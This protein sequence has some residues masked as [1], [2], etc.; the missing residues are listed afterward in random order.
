M[1][2]SKKRLIDMTQEELSQL[3]TLTISYLLDD[4]KKNDEKEY[5]KDDLVPRLVVAQEFSVSAVTIDKWVKF[6][7]FPKPIK[8]GRK[9]FFLREDLQ[10]FISKGKKNE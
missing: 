10:N 3:L 7:D 1:D 6:T 2:N 4:I 5:F 9:L 8:A